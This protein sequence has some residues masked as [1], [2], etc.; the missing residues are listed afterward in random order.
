MTWIMSIAR[1]T[2]SLATMLVVAAMAGC[3]PR[4]NPEVPAGYDASYA[5]VI[6]AARRE[7]RLDI[8]STTDA[9]QV[10]ELLAGFRRRY[11]GVAVA[12][13]DLPSSEIHRQFLADLEEGRPTADL[14]WSSAMDLQIKLVND[15][16]AQRYASPESEALP[17]WANW[18]NEAW[19]IT[20]EPIVMI[21]NRRLIAP[22]SVPTSHVEFRQLLERRSDV[23]LRGRVATYD[24]QRSAV[25]Y[26]YLLQ[27][28]GATRDLWRTVRALGAARARLFTTTE[29]II[30]DV[31]SG[32][33]AIG[34]NVV[35]SYAADEMRR[36]PQLGLVLP[37]DYTLIMSRIAVIPARAAHPS[38]AR[39]FLDYLL[40]REGQHAL[41]LHS[42]PP[43][44]RDVAA[45]P[46]LAVRAGS[47]RAIRVG[48]A[49]LV[50]QD[51]LTRKG[52]MAK[53]RAA[54]S[55]GQSVGPAN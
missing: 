24:P 44:R 30:A 37:H 16:F 14:L 2:R 35:G 15:G 25:G 21:Y 9:G 41:A 55:N 4:P 23:R 43:V 46:A 32:R 6:A 51:Q 19:G 54:F 1:A 27:D 40:S 17:E 8:W 3:A 18:K 52:T 20:A 12:Y 10:K 28:A 53:W 5:D 31:A 29:A 45:P 47:A 48:P 7:R 38:A 49:L 33:S 34:Y 13:H 11:P 36:S 22:A 50:H 39:L 42:M 26:L